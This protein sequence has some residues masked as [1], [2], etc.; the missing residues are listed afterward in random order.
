MV[1]CNSILLLTSSAR[2]VF[3]HAIR[4]SNMNNSLTIADEK[5]TG[6]L[7]TGC[8]NYLVA[9]GTARSFAGKTYSFVELRLS[10]LTATRN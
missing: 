6:F 1:R 3:A 4:V 2:Q 5:V 9:T 7:V 10:P 8:S